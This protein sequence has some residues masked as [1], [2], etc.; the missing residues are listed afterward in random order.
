LCKSILYV[1][2]G[3]SNNSAALSCRGLEYLL[4]TFKNVQKF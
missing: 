3:P 4:N 2:N 1:A